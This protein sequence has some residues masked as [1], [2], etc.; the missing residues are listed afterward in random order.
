M[1]KS[2]TDMNLKEYCESVGINNLKDSEIKILETYITAQIMEAEIS[3]HNRYRRVNEIKNR[4]RMLLNN[5]TE[6]TQLTID[7][8]MLNTPIIT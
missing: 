2:I 6:E 7:L 1:S 3:V 8:N 4:N 5:L